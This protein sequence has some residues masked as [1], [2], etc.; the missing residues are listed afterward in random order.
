MVVFANYPVFLA[1]YK[2]LNLPFIKTDFF[3]P[4]SLTLEEKCSFLAGYKIESHL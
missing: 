4:N 2:D 3:L 1:K